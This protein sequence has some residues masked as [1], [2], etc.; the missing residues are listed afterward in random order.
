MAQAS[1]KEGNGGA[2][3]QTG[4]DF[5]RLAQNLARLLE[6]CGRALTAYFKPAG[7]EEHAE[8]STEFADAIRSLGRIAEHWV[9]DP[10]RALQAQ[11]SLAGKLLGLWAYSLRR[12]SG[13]QEKPPVPHNPADKRFAAP[14]WHEVPF[15]D[16]LRQAHAI[17]SQWADDLVLRAEDVD[18]RVRDKARFYL[19][20]ISSAI[21]PS[22]F[23]ATNPEVLKETWATSG[24]NLA[25]GAALL[26]KDL[27]AGKGRLKIS[28]TDDSKFE[29]G[30]NIATSPGK[31]IF[32]NDLIE[33]IQY[34]P[35]TEEVYKRPLLIIP[36]W[37]NKYYILDL[38]PEKSFVR[39]AVSEG[40]TVFMISWVNPD[41]R[42]RKKGFEAYM[43]EGIFA[44]LDA[45]KKAT[46]ESKVTAIGYC[47]GGTLLA[48]TLAYMA[49]TDDKRITSASF[50]TTQTDF[51]QA[52]DLRLLVDEER[53]R[54]L[55]KKLAKTGYLEASAMAQAFNMLRPE[56]LIWSYVVNNYMK[57][58]PP[59]AFD[60]LAWNADSTRMTEANHLAYLRDCYLEN[61]L[62][63]KRARFGG[64]ILDLSKVTLPVYHLATREDHI[65]PAKSVFLGAKLLGGKVRFVLAGSGHIAGV[66]NP[67]GKP[68]YQY[69]AGPPPA[70][71]FDSWLAAAVEHK[72]SWWPDWIK[73]IKRQSRKKVPARI[74]G[75][76]EL[77]PLCD[78][79]GEYVRVRY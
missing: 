69:W 6:Q 65:A 23:L 45:I 54:V 5:D 75:S 3:A 11:S 22:N 72:G 73:W 2:S 26:A 60:L 35:A 13:E 37:I 61:R 16:F 76:G 40:L 67:A 24:E 66:I 42:H 59:V 30:V 39:F 10:A 50:F 15:F 57:G 78:A 12:L 58:N 38:N 8:V 1:K 32:R 18:P 49:Q 25:R 4:P 27:E 17:V 7:P 31:V 9:S 29:L 70:G 43:R 55:E 14:E 47:I 74:P 44:A 28:Q 48:I 62:A 63:R 21:A 79:P 64:K 36:P 41:A 33:L 34:A 46:G 77:A 20:Q 68:K 52:G 51:S 71:E 56:E 19:R 53:L